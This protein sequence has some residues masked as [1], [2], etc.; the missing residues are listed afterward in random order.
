VLPWEVV[1][2]CNDMK[3]RDIVDKEVRAAIPRMRRIPPIAALAVL[4]HSTQRLKCSEQQAITELLSIWENGTVEQ[5]ATL[6][7]ATSVVESFDLSN[8][9]AAEYFSA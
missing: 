7:R 4:K 8:Y 5:K 1:K 3:I 6:I 2:M 9:I